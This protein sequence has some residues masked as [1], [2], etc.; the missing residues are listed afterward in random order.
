MTDLMFSLQTKDEITAAAT[1]GHV[2]PERCDEQ[3]SPL[4]LLDDAVLLDQMVRRPR[5]GNNVI[6][7]PGWENGVSGALTQTRAIYSDGVSPGG[8]EASD[9]L[10][11]CLP[12]LRSFIAAVFASAGQ[13]AEELW[14]DGLHQVL[15][16]LGVGGPGYRYV[17]G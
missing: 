10:L 6:R 12:A 4:K 5:H 3:R 13:Q 8:E 16:G 9:D 15:S 1:A 14:R 11:V 2:R 17:R 7:D